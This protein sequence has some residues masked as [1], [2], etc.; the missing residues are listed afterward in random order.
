L[1]SGWFSTLPCLP[2][3]DCWLALYSVTIGSVSLSARTGLLND[4]YV[5]LA[6][7]LIMPHHSPSTSSITILSHFLLAARPPFLASYWLLDSALLYTPCLYL[8]PFLSTIHLTLKMEA[9][10]SSK[11]LASYH[12]I[13]Q[14]NNPEDCVVNLHHHENLEF[15]Y[16]QSFDK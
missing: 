8:C 1:C 3:G 7:S 2:F 16:W 5:P 6:A 12:S 10:R 13:T 4:L 9:A 15:C 14:H 11:A